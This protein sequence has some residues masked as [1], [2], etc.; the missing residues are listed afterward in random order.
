MKIKR[1]RISKSDICV[2]E[3][4]NLY[5]P[6]ETYKG[7]QVIYL[8]DKIHETRLVIFDKDTVDGLFKWY[9]LSF[10]TTRSLCY[11]NKV[12]VPNHE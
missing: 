10:L 1:K 11:V 12:K 9:Q 3:Q 6:V 5:I 7:E 8:Q 2:D 4:G